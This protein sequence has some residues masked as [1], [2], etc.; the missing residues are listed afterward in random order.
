MKDKNIWQF[1]DNCLQQDILVTLLLVV[2][3]EGSSPGRVGFKMAVAENGSLQGTIGGGTVEHRFVHEAQAKLKKRDFSPFCRRQIH[4]PQAETDLS[5]MV[6]GGMQTVVLYPCQP[7][8]DLVIVKQILQIIEQQKSGVLHLSP[9]GMALTLSQHNAANNQ[10][11]FAAT[12]EWQYDENIGV[13]DTAYIVGGG[14]VGLA[15]SRILALLNF[16]IVVLDARTELNTLQNNLDANEKRITSFHQIEPYIPD[17]LQ[18]YVFI[19]TPN[20]RIDELVLRQLLNKK[21]G[22]IGLMG[23]VSKINKIMQNLEKDGI[24]STQLKK[25]HAPIG[26]PIKSHTPMEVAI[27]IAAEVIAIKNSTT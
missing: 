7:N 2:V 8:R 16:H 26:L 18:N 15:L 13:F 14:H 1:I 22:Y 27:S 3:S 24:P 19:V 4:N 20:H 5:G 6:C 17:G 10:F 9:S 23:S 11:Q 12:N 25:V 21:L